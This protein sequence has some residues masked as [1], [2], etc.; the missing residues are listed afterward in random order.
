MKPKIWSVFVVFILV[1]FLCPQGGE[2]GNEK[3][4]IVFMGP[5]VIWL[6][7]EVPKPYSMEELIKI[8][9]KRN[10][11]LTKHFK[12]DEFE[13]IGKYY[14]EAGMVRTC[15]DNFVFGVTAIADYFEQLKIKRKVTQLEFNTDLVYIDVDEHLALNPSP[16]NPEKDIVYTIYEIISISYDIEGRSPDRDTSSA[17]GGHS[18]PT[19]RDGQG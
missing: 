10:S 7:E 1:F 12:N 11:K 2:S 14:G 19:F 16:V 8:F 6:M 17:G 15:Y 4:K 5:G 18:R 9:K 3:D 13:E